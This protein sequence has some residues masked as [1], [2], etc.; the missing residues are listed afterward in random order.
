MIVMTLDVPPL[1]REICKVLFTGVHSRL[2]HSCP[3]QQ[4][5][6]H[7]PIM[8]ANT[9]YTIFLVSALYIGFEETSSYWALQFFSNFSLLFIGHHQSTNFV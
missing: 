1:S 7:R 3:E 9:V 4:V 8:F 6:L 2:Y 5:K